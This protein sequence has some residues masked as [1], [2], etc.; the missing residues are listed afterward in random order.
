ML[1]LKKCFGSGWHILIHGLSLSCLNKGWIQKNIHKI[2]VVKKN[3][4]PSAIFS[5]KCILYMIFWTAERKMMQHWTIRKSHHAS[6]YFLWSYKRRTKVVFPVQ[7]KNDPSSWKSTMNVLQYYHHD[8][9]YITPT[10]SLVSGG[11]RTVC[12]SAKD[13][14]GP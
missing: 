14:R 7:E 10:F 3:D 4:D 11:S 12:Q 9:R 6:I 13:Y 8:L 1:R 2:C 5:L